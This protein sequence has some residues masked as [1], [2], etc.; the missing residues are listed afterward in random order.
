[1]YKA[2]RAMLTAEQEDFQNET[3]FRVSAQILLSKKAK[4]DQE[5][6]CTFLVPS[7]ASFGSQQ[8]WTV[9]Q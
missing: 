1:M 2:E 4:H 8:I 6:C 3:N 7:A 5:G 9:R